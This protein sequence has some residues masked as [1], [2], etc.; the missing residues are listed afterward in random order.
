MLASLIF[1]IYFAK[2]L[3]PSTSNSLKHSW[4]IVIF[5]L[6]LLFQMAFRKENTCL[7][8]N[9]LRSS[10]SQIGVLKLC[11]IH[12]KAYLLK[13]LFNNMAGL[14]AW[15]FIKKRLW[16]RYFPVNF[17]QF[18]KKPYLQN[19]WW[20]LL[21]ILPFQPNFLSVDHSLFFPSLF[22]FIIDN[23]NYG[24]LHRKCLKMK[25]FLLFTIVYSKINKCC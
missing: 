2:S 22:S 10:C 24:S 20:L 17:S 8:P 9:L 13:L 16:H 18:F 5:V 6:L 15:N 3:F 12:V 1:V 19:T 11:K 25:I 7:T 4:F 23:C 21:L 14:E